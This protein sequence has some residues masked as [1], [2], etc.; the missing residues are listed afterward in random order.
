MAAALATQ[1]AAGAVRKVEFY[2]SEEETFPPGDV[3]EMLRTLDEAR[4]PK[5][6]LQT[7]KGARR[8]AALTPAVDWSPHQYARHVLLYVQPV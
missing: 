7:P 3:S 1:E 8:P 5:V 6:G 4:T 2:F